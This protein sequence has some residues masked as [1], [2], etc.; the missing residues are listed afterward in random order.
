MLG[1]SLGGY[2]AIRMAAHDPRVRAVAAVSPPYALDV[3]WNITLAGMRRELAALYGIEEREMGAQIERITLAGTI[4]TL[5]CPLMLAAGG[6]DH[7]TPGSEAWRI[8]EDARC[9]REMV[10]YP[11][12]GHECFN[13]LGDLR[14]RVVN[15][16]ARQ[17]ETHAGAHLPNGSR[18]A[19]GYAPLGLDDRDAAWTAAEA[20]DPDFA[21]ALSGEASR[22]VWNPAESPGVPVRWRW[23]WVVHPGEPIEII[24]RIEPGEPG[25]EP[26]PARRGARADDA[27][28]L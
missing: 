27:L 18:T 1:L 11:R 26:T 17:L 25:L 6:H 12:A 24:H 3:Y 13:M 28:A 21:D 22:P 16:L 7:L 8:F 5:R 20:V 15:W 23:P 2:L 14:P 9:E 10:F 19:N 4:D